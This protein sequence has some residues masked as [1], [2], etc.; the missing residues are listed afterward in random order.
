M[1]AIGAML[2]ISNFLTCTRLAILAFSSPESSAPLVPPPASGL[3]TSTSACL[4]AACARLED[5]EDSSRLRPR[6][7][8]LSGRAGN[9]PG[10]PGPGRMGPAGGK[11]APSLPG[12]KSTKSVTHASRKHATW[13]YSLL[14]PW[15]VQAIPSCGKQY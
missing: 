6:A 9:R 14:L 1:T 10:D 2:I 13:D 15:T 3:T 8:P 4:P 11:G 7:R 5:P 12:A